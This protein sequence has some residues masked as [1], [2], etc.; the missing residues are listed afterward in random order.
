MDR[1]QVYANVQNVATF[2][3]YSGLDPVIGAFNQDPMRQNWD[4]GRYPAPRIYTFG[5]NIDF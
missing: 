4:L 5:L 2:T 3:E 1:V